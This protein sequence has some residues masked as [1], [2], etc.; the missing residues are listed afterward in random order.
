MELSVPSKGNHRISVS[1]LQQSRLV[2]ILELRLIVS[3]P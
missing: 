2:Q 1:I 3:T